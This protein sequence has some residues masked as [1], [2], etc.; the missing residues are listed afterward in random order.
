MKLAAYTASIVTFCLLGGCATSK[1][2]KPTNINV[3]SA[4]TQVGTGLAGMRAA[5]R[6]V[7]GAG[8]LIP[9]QVQITFDVGASDTDNGS[10][11]IQASAPAASPVTVGGSGSAATTQSDNRSNQVTVTLT[12]ILFAPPNIL[13]DNPATLDQLLTTLNKHGYDLYVLDDKNINPDAKQSVEALLKS[14][15]LRLQQHLNGLS[16]SNGTTPS[17]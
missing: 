17:N 12:N 3:E 1:F 9:S 5:E 4:L 15:N 6:S 13:A 8:G 7:P 10:L 16:N 14:C 11:T 2:G